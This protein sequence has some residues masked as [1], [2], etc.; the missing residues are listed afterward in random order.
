ML[1]AVL[2]AGVGEGA[3]FLRTPCLAPGQVE[4][5]FAQLGAR[6]S[7]FRC[8]FLQGGASVTKHD[9]HVRGEFLSRRTILKTMGVGVLATVP[10]AALAQAPRLGPPST[11]T[12]PPRDFGPNGA[13]TTYFSDPD[14]LSVD[15]S[16]DGYVQPNSAITRL[17]TGA[18]WMEGPAWSSQGRYLVFS[19]IPNNRQMRWIEDDGQVTRFPAA[20]E[21]QQRQ[22]LRFPGPAALL[23][24]SHAA[25]RPLRARRLGHDPG[26]RL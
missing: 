12:S 6:A 26:G 15:P 22:H 21:Q 17:W 14:I 24:A 23:R 13:P 8:H 25:R 11:I 1:D 7:L 5:Y 19:D 3:R 2:L 4:C 10:G 20:V 9:F 18:L 16:F